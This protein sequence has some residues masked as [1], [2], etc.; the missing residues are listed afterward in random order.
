MQGHTLPFNVHFVVRAW[1]RTK[2]GLAAK[3]GAIKNAIDP[4]DER[5]AVF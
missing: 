5:C 1:D 4:R 2:Y 3:L